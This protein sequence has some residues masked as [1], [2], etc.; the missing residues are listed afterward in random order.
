VDPVM[1][2]KYGSLL[3]QNVITHKINAEVFTFCDGLE[4]LTAITVKSTMI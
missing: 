3:Q 1:S 4:I 2:L